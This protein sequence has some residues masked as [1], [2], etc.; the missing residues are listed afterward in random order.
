MSSEETEGR[1]CTMSPAH[2]FEPRQKRNPSSGDFRDSI[3]T[4]VESVKPER[5]SSTEVQP[6]EEFTPAMYTELTIALMQ[7]SRK[8]FQAGEYQEAEMAQRQVI[9]YLDDREVILQIPFENRSQMQENLAQI[10]IRMQQYDQAKAIISPMLRRE[11][12]DSDQKWRLYHMLAEIYIGQNKLSE[13]EQVAKRAFVGREDSLGKGHTLIQQSADIL[14]SIYE[15]QGRD[16]AAQAF[17]NLHPDERV[18]ALAPKVSKY[19]GKTRVEWNPDLSVNMNSMTKAGK[20]LLINAIS[21]GN[22]EMVYQVLRNGADVEARCSGGITPL[23]YAVIHGQAKIAGVLLSRAAVVDALT[24]GWTALQKAAALGDYVLV[25]LLLEN[26]ADI[27]ARGPKR[28]APNKGWE[29]S[30]RKSCENDYLDE[31]TDLDD[32]SGWTALLRAADCGNEGMVGF[33]LDKGADIEVCNPAK[34][35]P[36]SCAAENQHAQV[37][38]LLISRDANIKTQDDFGWQPLHRAQVHYGGDDIAAK[39]IESGADVNAKCLNGKTPLHY[40]VEREN[41]SMIRL[42]LEL[43]AD[44]SAQDIARRAP[45]HTAIDCR[46]EHMVHLLLDLGADVGIKDGDG[47]D[48]MGAANHALR[49]SPEITKLL[50]RHIKDLKT[51][52]S[53]KVRESRVPSPQ[54]VGSMDALFGTKDTERHSGHW[55]SRKGRKSR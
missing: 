34:A 53:K 18:C 15:K 44:M 17:R 54:S 41:E 40:A 27:E 30:R 29:K 10:Y 50:G 36:L 33:L 46:S 37:V 11:S 24:S 28:F 49:K 20:T 52:G 3:S 7:E 51:R 47:R 4:A 31:E 13:A 6:R 42:L 19:V 43:G 23:M 25:N 39:L 26:R 16:D 12:H 9:E 32:D 14:V 21:S 55:W 38:N 2:Q 5:A 35:T 48:A 45:L 1:H 8:H 22:D